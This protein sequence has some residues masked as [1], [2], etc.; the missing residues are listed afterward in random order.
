MEGRVKL[1]DVRR[2]VVDEELRSY[3]ENRRGDIKVALGALAMTGV[4]VAGLLLQP[5]KVW[6]RGEWFE[7]GGLLHDALGY[8]GAVLLVRGVAV[9]LT[10]ASLWWLGSILWSLSAAGTERRRR[11]IAAEQP[12]FRQPWET[13]G[14]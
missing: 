13:P 3:R 8:G 9:A 10:A 11:R 2:R 6:A 7:P 14:S 5:A 12:R 1:E 4:C